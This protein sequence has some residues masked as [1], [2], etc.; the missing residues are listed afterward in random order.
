MIVW[1]IVFSI[2]YDFISLDL[3]LRQLSLDIYLRDLKYHHKRY[4]V[5]ARTKGS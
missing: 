1:Y 4:V 2:Q 5:H 3:F